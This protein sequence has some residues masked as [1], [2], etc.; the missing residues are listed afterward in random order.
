MAAIAE[1]TAR[2]MTVIL[3]W[4]DSS[5]VTVKTTAQDLGVSHSDYVRPSCCV[6]AAIA[7]VTGGNM[8]CWFVVAAL[9]FPLHF[10]VIHGNNI[11]PIGCCM[12]GATLG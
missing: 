6:M 7:V 5:I 3:G 11:L 9:A 4:G 10:I 1:I 8:S 12:A 2:N